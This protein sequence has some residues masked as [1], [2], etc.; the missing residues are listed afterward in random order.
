MT[1]TF[2]VL[3]DEHMIRQQ[4]PGL[5]SARLPAAKVN[6]TARSFAG[7]FADHRTNNNT[8]IFSKTEQGNQIQKEPMS[9]NMKR[10]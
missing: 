2:V 1:C 4:K 7:A 9:T 3:K 8:N 10:K 5:S 6:N